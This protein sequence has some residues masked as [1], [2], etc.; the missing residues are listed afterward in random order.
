MIFFFPRERFKIYTHYSRFWIRFCCSSIG[1]SKFLAIRKWIEIIWK[2]GNILGTDFFLFFLF[3]YLRCSTL[4][5]L[6]LAM[7]FFKFPFYVYDMR[8]Q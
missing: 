3:I 4:L 5:I 1:F 2:E 8:A 6:I 7:K